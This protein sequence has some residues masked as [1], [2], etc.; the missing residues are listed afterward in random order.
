[1]NSRFWRGTCWIALLVP[2]VLSAGTSTLRI[3]DT[4]TLVL[5][6][7]AKDGAVV[8]ADSGVYENNKLTR[9]NAIRILR[10]GNLGALTITG[11]TRA[12]NA[13]KEIN[14]Y[15]IATKCADSS[16]DIGLAVNCLSN[17]ISPQLPKHAVK[18]P[19]ELLVGFYLVG[20]VNGRRDFELLEVEVPKGN[21]IPKL[22]P[23]HVEPA[24]GFFIGFGKTEF[25]MEV[26]AG[27]V[28][29]LASDP[30]VKLSASRQTPEQRGLYTV[31]EMLQLIKFLLVE[32]E[33]P[34]AHKYFHDVPL[35]GPNKFV[36]IDSKSGFRWT[37]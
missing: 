37:N 27:R 36:V 11:G 21:G 33:S 25:P 17:K 2:S 26:L 13:G 28:P 18:L 4:G 9:T 3:A 14:F 15:Q 31:Q 20:Y 12:S 32:T 10:V 1:M 23:Q 19:R 22:K 30:N 8:A 5:M 35:H 24:E 7:F 16:S 29:E 34:L 6:G